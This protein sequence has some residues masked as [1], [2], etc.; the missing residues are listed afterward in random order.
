MAE[1]VREMLVSHD[2]YET[3][4]AVLENSQL[5]E[6][7]V[8]RAKRSV[9]GNI[10]L[11]KVT[12]V[13]PGIQAAF[14][15]IGLEKNAFLYVDDVRGSVQDPRMRRN[16]SGLLTAGQ[17]VM[18]QVV[19]DPMGTKGARI[20]MEISIAGR[21]AVFMPRTPHVGVSKKIEEP[22]R[23][24]LTEFVAPYVPEGMGMIVRTAAADAKI[25]DLKA[26]LEF[27]SRV[28]KRIQRQAADGL[29]PA[30]LYT[31][32]DLAMRLVR[33][34]FSEQF[35]RLV[36][37]DKAVYEKLVS[38]I[39]RSSPN[40]VAKMHLHRDPRKALFDKHEAV[41]KGIN[42]A[43]RR[44]VDLPSGGQIV[45]D[46]TEALIAIDVNTGSYVGR[47]D[48]EETVLKTNLEAAE[49]VARQLRLR[50]L[51]GIIIIDFI[52]MEL[53]SS[54]KRLVEHLEWCLKQDRTKSKISGISALGLVELTRKNTTDGLFQT[55]T[56]VCPR[57]YGQGRSL[58]AYTRKVA[59]ERSIREYCTQ[60]TSNSFLFAVNSETYDIITSSGA[61]L[62]ALVKH[63][64]GKDVRIVGDPKL[65]P[66][67]VEVLIEGSN[68]KSLFGKFKFLR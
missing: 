33:D 32:I 29:A 46:K 27:L 10:Y 62:P 60:S 3:R 7:Y 19:R 67:Q 54:K 13:L 58:S 5:V 8:E 37:D 36:V 48:L 18:V 61:N 16:I 23:T 4:V 26:D 21:F 64:T 35:E 11:G 55:L 2:N 34:V 43:L 22:R 41:G 57:C 39:K 38:F 12:D 68:P 44:E 42:Q 28:W 20:T 59:V 50:D 51:G 25:A 49:M 9:V 40:L 1:M 47:R 24:E 56:E 6:L 31:E 66:V 15:D 30:I 14:V 63:D 52:D 65:E 45:I 53:E 17:K